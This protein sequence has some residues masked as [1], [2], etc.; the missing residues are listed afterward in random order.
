MATVPI[1]MNGSVLGTTCDARL[2]MSIDSGTF[3]GREVH[4]RALLGSQSNDVKINQDSGETTAFRIADVVDCKERAP[5]RH[6]VTDKFDDCGG[7]CKSIALG[8][9]YWY[10]RNLSFYLFP[11]G[12]QPCIEFE[13]EYATADSAGSV[14]RAKL[15]AVAGNSV[16]YLAGPK[17][18]S[19]GGPQ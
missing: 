12:A 18:E 7:S 19:T 8:A 6:L 16:V 5:L 4:L 10:G 11:D 2:M 9:G 14:T 13:L 15:R 17:C 1:T 3:D